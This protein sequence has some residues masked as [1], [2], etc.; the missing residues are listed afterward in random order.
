MN[1]DYSSTVVSPCVLVY[2]REWLVRSC[3]ATAGAELKNK[4]MLKNR[5]FQINGENVG[6]SCFVSVKKDQ[7][8]STLSLYIE[9]K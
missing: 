7:Y 6:Y 3:D 4:T 1:T 5:D 8:S 2:V 9:L